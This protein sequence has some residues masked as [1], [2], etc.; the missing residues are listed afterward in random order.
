[1]RKGRIPGCF[2]HYW[3]DDPVC[4]ACP[5]QDYCEEATIEEEEGDEEEFCEEVGEE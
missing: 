4:N 1:M 2:G 5:W 3:F